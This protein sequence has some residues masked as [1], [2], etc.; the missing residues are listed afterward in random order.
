MRKI[1]EQNGVGPQK[2]IPALHAA[3]D[4]VAVRACVR[5]CVRAV[6]MHVLDPCEQD[7]AASTETDRASTFFL[8]HRHPYGCLPV[9]DR[10]VQPDSSAPQ[11]APHLRQDS[12]HLHRHSSH[13]A[14][15]HGARGHRRPCRRGGRAHAARCCAG[16][17]SGRGRRGARAPACAEHG[18]GS[19]KP[20]RAVLRTCKHEFSY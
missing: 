4:D 14:A 15:G 13:R 17:G 16:G 8:P 7:E 5:A 20:M 6:R 10:I 2:V 3:T 11:S 19:L 18:H 12:P 9:P 1:A